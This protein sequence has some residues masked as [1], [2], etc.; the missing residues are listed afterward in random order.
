MADDDRTQ[1]HIDA[2]LIPPSGPG[3]SQSQYKHSLGFAD[4]PSDGKWYQCVFDSAT[5]WTMKRVDDTSLYVDKPV[6]Q[7]GFCVVNP[8]NTSS[9]IVNPVCPTHN[10]SS[11]IVLRK[12][13]SL[14]LQSALE[15]Y[16]RHAEERQQYIDKCAVNGSDLLNMDTKA[17]LSIVEAYV[18]TDRY[19][20]SDNGE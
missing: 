3:A 1:S 18:E 15:V 19:Q 17:V 10:P 2:A 4:I 7:C 14:P 11:Q 20:N 16:R 9:L 12:V 6:A 5:G 13:G 8:D